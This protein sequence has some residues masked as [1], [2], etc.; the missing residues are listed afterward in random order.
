MT[1]LFGPGCF[2]YDQDLPG[3]TSGNLHAIEYFAAAMCGLMGLFIVKYWVTPAR[4]F[5]APFR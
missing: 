5:G 3:V 1:S 4:F 2:T